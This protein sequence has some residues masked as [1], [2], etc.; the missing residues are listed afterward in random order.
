MESCETVPL[1]TCLPEVV[2]KSEDLAE[3]KYS[4]GQHVLAGLYWLESDSEN[5]VKPSLYEHAYLR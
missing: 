4:Q 5:L 1:R 2:D 3:T